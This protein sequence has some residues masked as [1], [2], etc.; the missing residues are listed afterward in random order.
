LEKLLDELEEI[1]I[2]RGT[3]G[4]ENFCATGGMLKM[5]PLIFS[6]P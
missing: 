5:L 4:N 3:R 1:V 2:V 6:H